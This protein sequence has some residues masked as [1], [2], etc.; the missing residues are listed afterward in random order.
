LAYPG[1]DGDKVLI[2]N[3]LTPSF[4]NSATIAALS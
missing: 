2:Q 1:V 4:V 3:Y